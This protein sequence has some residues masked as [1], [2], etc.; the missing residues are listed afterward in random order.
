MEEWIITTS[1][2]PHKYQQVFG[3]V[4]IGIY[5]NGKRGRHGLMGRNSNFIFSFL[6][7]CAKVDFIIVFEGIIARSF[8]NYQLAGEEGAA[9]LRY[10][11]K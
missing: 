8:G 10:C 1:L 2:L 9:G 7:K 5:T 3:I 6:G 11:G 4:A